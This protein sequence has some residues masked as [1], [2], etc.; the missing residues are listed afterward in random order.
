MTEIRKMFRFEHFGEMALITNHNIRTAS[1]KATEL[2]KVAVLNK[3]D[4]FMATG[5][6][7]IGKLKMK[8]DFFST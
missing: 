1:V 5:N 8:I 6:E 7:V 3:N 4:F 2:T